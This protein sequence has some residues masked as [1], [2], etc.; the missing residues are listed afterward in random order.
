MTTP[1]DPK[2]PINTGS[3]ND[4][5]TKDQLRAML[6]DLHTRMD[7]IEQALESMRE[8]LQAAASR[9]TG[10]APEEKFLAETVSKSIDQNGKV[11]YKMHGGRYKL[12]VRIWPEVMPLLGVDE[13]TLEHGPNKIDPPVIVRVEIGKRAGRS[14]LGEEPGQQYDY[15]R[16]ILGPA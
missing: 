3:K 15:A 2:G 12:G 13:S 6:R 8:G 16:K 1:T 11:A 4:D 10:D 5:I 9:P 14:D 7:G